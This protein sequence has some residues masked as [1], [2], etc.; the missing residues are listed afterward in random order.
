MTRPEDNSHSIPDGF[1]SPSMEDLSVIA[2]SRRE[3]QKLRSKQRRE[4]AAK[5]AGV[6]PGDRLCNICGQVIKIVSKEPNKE[7]YCIVCEK[8][9]KAGQTAIVSMDGRHIF[10]TSQL[11]DVEQEK[12]LFT[13]VTDTPPKVW[14]P[15][16][17]I[18]GCVL[19]TT[20]EKMDKLVKIYEGQ[21][22]KN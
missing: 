17:T 6:N 9:L 13:A 1:N 4:K 18:R 5:I 16:F 21:N 11:E 8:T 19:P 22:V 20:S 12:N 3:L 15:D 14:P 7:G 10:I 2:R